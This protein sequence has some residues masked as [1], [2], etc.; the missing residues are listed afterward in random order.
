MHGRNA[1]AGLLVLRLI[2]GWIF[3][4]HGLGKLIGPPFPGGGMDGFAQFLSGLFAPLGPSANE[5]LA[6]LV[7]V[8]EAGGGLLL[9]LGWQTAI[10][11][12]LIIINMLVAIAKVHFDAGIFGRGGWEKN[13]IL[14][15]ALLCLLLAGPGAVSLDGRR[16]PAGAA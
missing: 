9:I 3:L 15:A 6:W 5:L 13:L 4:W 12:S 2:T 16:R 14:V 10:A 1:A 8:V 7:M 11:A